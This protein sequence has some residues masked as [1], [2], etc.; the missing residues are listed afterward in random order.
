MSAYLLIGKRSKRTRERRVPD[1]CSFEAS[2]RERAHKI[3]QRTLQKWTLRVGNRRLKPR[4][5]LLVRIAPKDV[6]Y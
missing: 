3:L 2:T 6:W 4:H 5:I 1:F